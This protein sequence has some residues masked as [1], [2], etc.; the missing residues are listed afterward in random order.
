MLLPPGAICPIC[1]E[2]FERPEDA[3]MTSGDFLPKSDPLAR[4]CNQPIHWT[5]Y[6]EWPERPRFARA[7]VEAWVKANRK[8]PFWWTVCDDDDVYLSVNPQRAIEEVA[9]RL[10]AIGS[11]IRV[12]LTQWDAFLEEPTKVVPTLHAL[13]IEVLSPLLATLRERFPDA[14]SIVDAID[15]NEKQT[16]GRKS[17]K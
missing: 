17:K 10:Y 15:P 1:N 16:A 14:H 7:Y 6:A 13:E 9:V 3:F 12:P 11:D 4:F 5:C 8:N 2:G